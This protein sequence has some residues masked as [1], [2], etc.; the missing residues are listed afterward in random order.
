MTDAATELDQIADRFWEAS[1]DADPFMATGIGAPGHD[2]ELPPLDRSQLDRMAQRMREARQAAETVSVEDLSE[3]DRVT[4]QA[5]LAAIEAS[6]AFLEADAA[7]YTVNPMGGPQVEFLNLVDYQA[8]ESVAQGRDMV[9]R[10]R[11]MGP[12]IDTLTDRQ[13]A[14]I[15]EGRPPVR[16]LA[17]RVLNELDALLAQPG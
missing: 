16:I 1:L 4:R 3:D 10:W 2:A 13:R 8:S 9:E 14:S 11:G 7:A 5:L 15:G 6:L 12:W 17:E